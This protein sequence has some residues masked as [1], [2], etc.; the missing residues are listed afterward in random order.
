MKATIFFSLF[1]LYMVLPTAAQEFGCHWICSPDPNDTTQI[2]FRRVYFSYNKPK[3]ASL[4]IISTGRFQVYVNERNITGDVLMPSM[5]S[6]KG[7]IKGLTF[8]ITRFLQPEKNTIAVWYSPKRGIYSDKQLS[9]SY[10]GKTAYDTRFCYNTDGTWD[11]RSTG[12]YTLPGNCEY[13][14]G[15]RECPDWKSDDTGYLKWE[16]AWYSSDTTT[17]ACHLE[18]SF[19]PSQ[20][21]THTLYPVSIYSDSMGYHI[22]FG[23]RFKGWIRLTIRDARPGEEI[24]IGGLT[25]ICNGQMDEQACRRFTFDTQKE[26]IISGD[27][28]FKA[29]QIQ[30]IEGLEIQSYFHQSYLY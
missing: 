1:F 21:I 4:T 9:L 14:N 30:S 3:Q 26:V 16:K 10:F 18:S 19:Y 27:K 15:E 22:D 6:V 24:H 17:Y 7:A 25:Y 8:D 13:V 20:K 28:N 5:D 29:S 23:K 12:A 2:Q 11:C